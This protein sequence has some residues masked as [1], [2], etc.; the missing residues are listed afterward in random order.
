MPSQ[1]RR[2][3]Q[4]GV[5]DAHDDV[6]YWPGKRVFII[7]VLE[8]DTIGRDWTRGCSVFEEHSP[9]VNTH[10]PIRVRGWGSASEPAKGSRLLRLGRLSFLEP[11]AKEGQR[12]RD[13]E[14]VGGRDGD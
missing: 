3:A 7:L 13:T 2:P 12:E 4:K 1:Q 11:M 14:R 8:Q 6:L 5:H 9:A 10:F